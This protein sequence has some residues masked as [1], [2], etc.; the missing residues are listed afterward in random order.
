MTKTHNH[1][2]GLL[3]RLYSNVLKKCALINLGAMFFAFGFAGSANAE[4]IIIPNDK[5][6]EEGSVNNWDSGD[7]YTIS[8]SD[9]AILV[10][11]YTS[12][13]NLTNKS[14]VADE[15]GRI[16]IEG[17]VSAYN[18]ISNKTVSLKNQGISGGIISSTGLVTDTTDA[19]RIKLNFT[20]FTNNTVAGE[21]NVPNS[22]MI[23]N[24][25]IIGI[26]GE[27]T[28]KYVFKDLDIGGG[29]SF[30]D[31][32]I[33]IYDRREAGTTDGTTEIN[34]GVLYSAGE[35][36]INGGANPL[37]FSNNNVIISRDNSL[38]GAGYY[39]VHGGAIY[40]KGS[41]DISGITVSSNRINSQYANGAGI[42]HTHTSDFSSFSLTNSTITGNQ[43]GVSK[44]GRGGGLAVYALT[45]NTTA[46]NL[47]GVSFRDNVITVYGD[48]T[49][50]KAYGGAIYHNAITDEISKMYIGVGDR[51][52]IVFSGNKAVL[53]A[54]FSGEAETKGGAIYNGQYGQLEIDASTDQI[55]FSENYAQKGGAIYNLADNSSKTVGTDSV[56]SFLQ[57]N[58][59]QDGF[60]SFSK[61]S[62]E[63]GGAIYNSNRAVTN[64]AV[65]NGTLEFK[66]N[67][68]SQA[69][70]AI[71]N[72]ENAT[73]HIDLNN[74]AEIMMNYNV[75]TDGSAV[76]G[77]AIYNDGNIEIS[78]NEVKTVAFNWNDAK[79]GKGGAIYN[80][81][82]V[83]ME[84]TNSS[85]VV[86]KENKA[87][88]GGG[89]YN[90]GGEF[91]LFTN[92]GIGFGN[93]IADNG[94]A[95]YNTDNSKID[96]YV[97][98][99][100]SIIFRG[101]S[102]SEKGGA[103]YNDT[104][105]IINL[106]LSGT[107]ILNFE[108]ATDN[109]YNLGE[110][111]VFGT[112]KNEFLY[113][114]NIEG[115]GSLNAKEV[116]FT[117]NNGLIDG[118]Q[119]L[120][121][122]NS[123]ITLNGTSVLNVDSLDVF[124]ATNLNITT[125][126]IVNYVGS[127]ASPD[128]VLAE[129]LSHSGVLNLKDGISSTINVTNL[130]ANGGWVYIDVNKNTSDKIVISGNV[131]GVTNFTF[132]GIDQLEKGHKITFAQTNENVNPEDFSFVFDS[133]NYV[134]IIEQGTSVHDGV[135]DWYL[136]RSGA[137]RTEALNYII[138]PRA[139]VEQTR[140]VMYDV[141]KNN[142]TPRVRYEYGYKGT[143]RKVVD[144]NA[145][146]SLWANPISRISTF[147]APSE[148]DAKIWGVDFG[149]NVNTSSN[150][151]TGFVVSYRKGDYADGGSDGDYF[152]YGSRTMD[153]ESVLV[154]LYYSKYFGNMYFNGSIY[155]GQQKAR[156]DTD[157]NVRSSTS[158][159]A[160]GLQFE[161]GYTSRLNKR[162]TITPSLRV[163]YDYVNFDDFTDTL[164]K[165][166]TIEDIHDI[167]LE[168]GVKYEYQFN[169]ER[170][171]PT[172]GYIKPSIIQLIENGGEVTI[173]D[174][175]IDDT[176]QNETAV[177]LEMGGEATLMPNFTVGGFG[178]YTI[179]SDYN[180][181]EFGGHMRYTW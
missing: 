39:L 170:Q 120:N 15:G 146:V 90:T 148:I 122:A 168:L 89:I 162:E 23:I 111:N 157:E 179:G 152:A 77:G 58:V 83:N 84:Y 11:N 141:A 45:T 119:K 14:F 67:S 2:C 3:I 144:E 164:D 10:G 62:A 178:N 40:N 147:K 5:A 33:T 108:T 123:S 126:A 63:M 102:A 115:T 158:G 181:F 165:K 61:N 4:N 180:G 56:T 73:F 132:D 155:G 41:M 140:S 98:G 72:K 85:Q 49:E 100:N 112:N 7:S 86:I 174:I 32:T 82:V 27:Q 79:T 24:G 22:E 114:S 107:S 46:V 101:N 65:E 21:L 142:N 80:S 9:T 163:S 124:S 113:N 87:S 109:I 55:V 25:G 150:G 166:V 116:N 161:T 118:A 130:E 57:M 117:I 104:D 34:G 53:D 106:T 71:Y 31:N 97:D 149:L 64:I 134:F 99:G 139:A 169:N 50:G 13:I 74:N 145:K 173:K 176:L 19:N 52:S 37:S 135:M 95:I 88:L 103:I 35:V 127:E 137:V 92:T 129:T 18:N 29:T 6:V 47:A 17:S 66:E 151:K 48:S 143:L 125:D 28:Q 138:L 59:A 105:S 93:N 110:I 121:F 20:N 44:E 128:I 68:V 133:E 54:G 171:Y 16:A 42:Y 70:G 94:G 8:V 1:A 156:M 153:M 76:D 78:G 91:I 172:T 30:S 175:A 38:S 51:G 177:R 154:G 136:Y 12:E 131:S 26:A 43:I 159:I 75:A 36:A 160:T 69:G 96:L 167:E 81:G 60:L